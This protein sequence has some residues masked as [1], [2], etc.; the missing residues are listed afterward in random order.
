[1]IDPLLFLIIRLRIELEMRR[2]SYTVVVLGFMC[3]SLG[4]QSNSA[5]T[6]VPAPHTGAISATGDYYPKQ[7][8]SNAVYTPGGS[9]RS[10]SGKT[11]SP[12]ARGPIG[13]IAGNHEGRQISHEESVGAADVDVIR[14]PVRGP[15]QN[16]VNDTFRESGLQPL[17]NPIEL[18]TPPPSAGGA[19]LKEDGG[20]NWVSRQ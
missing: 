7:K 1:M 8:Q 17:E 14:I 16:Q 20:D 4:C 5:V 9:T 13:N 15:E 19:V 2:A 10:E 11:W 12:R 18:E 3:L 6:R